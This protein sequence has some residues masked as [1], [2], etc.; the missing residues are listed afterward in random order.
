MLPGPM[1]PS[2]WRAGVPSERMALA[3]WPYPS[4]TMAAQLSMVS[5]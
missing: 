2:G 3:G 4:A 1:V 5:S